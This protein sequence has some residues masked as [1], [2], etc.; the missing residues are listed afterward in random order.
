VHL[1]DSVHSIF[2]VFV[3]RVN[4]SRRSLGF[5]RLFD[6]KGVWART[7]TQSASTSDEQHR[8]ASSRTTGRGSL[9]AREAVAVD[10]EVVALQLA[11]AESGVNRHG[12]A[13]GFN[14]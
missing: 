2:F 4:E 11:E 8:M 13:R 6:A 12:F 3:Q 5:Q 10:G 9:P 14:S 7:S 1:A